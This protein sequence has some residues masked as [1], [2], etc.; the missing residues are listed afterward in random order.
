MKKDKVDISINLPIATRKDQVISINR[1]MI[2]INKLEKNIICFGTIHPNFGNFNDV[3]N[4]IKFLKENKIKGI[5]LHPEYQNFYPDDWKMFK[6]YE[7]CTK[8]NIT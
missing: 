4:E 2:Y 8:Y 7:L 3:E 5:K 6:I 1:K